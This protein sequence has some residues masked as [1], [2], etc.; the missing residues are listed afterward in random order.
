[1]IH[2][3]EKTKE[4]FKQNTDKWGDSY[5]EDVRVSSLKEV[6]LLAAI[7]NQRS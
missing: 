5:F 2:T 7:A 3:T 4:D 6:G 1:M